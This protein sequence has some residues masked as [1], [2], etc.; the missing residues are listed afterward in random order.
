VATVALPIVS[1]KSANSTSV[2][3]ILLKAWFVQSAS[4]EACKL[5][6]AG[7]AEAEAEVATVAEAEAEVA[8]VGAAEAEVAT[9]AV[10]EAEVAGITMVVAITEAGA[11]VLA[12]VAGMAAMTMAIM[13][14]QLSIA[15]TTMSS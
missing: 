2:V 15:L 7:A 13:A 5:F 11:V 1:K 8:T 10:T 6:W 3:R 4:P 14:H 9:G 12:G